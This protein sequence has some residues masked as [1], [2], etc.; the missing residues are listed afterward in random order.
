M[1]HTLAQ[2]FPRSCYVIYEQCRGFPYAG[3]HGAALSEWLDF[4]VDVGIGERKACKG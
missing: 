1:G 2:V 4:L 3:L